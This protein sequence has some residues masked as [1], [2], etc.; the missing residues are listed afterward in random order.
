MSIFYKDIVSNDFI[1]SN[2]AFKWLEFNKKINVLKEKYPNLMTEFKS[3]DGFAFPSRDYVTRHKNLLNKEKLIQISNVN[4]HEWV[5]T[6]SQ[7]F[8]YL[9]K[10]FL[11]NKKR[12]YLN[13]EYILI[14][15][16]GGSDISKDI[17]SYFDNSFNAF[18]NQ[19]V[20]AFYTESIDKDILFYFYGFTKS[21]FFKEQWL[22]KGGIQKNTGA[23]ERKN[24]YIP[25]INKPK[26]ITYISLLT[27]AIINKEKII[28]ER[29]KQILETIENELV[30]NQKSEK[31]DFKY[32]T[33]NEISNIG[34]MDTN[35]YRENFKIIDFSIKNYKNGFQTIFDLGFTLS[36]GQNLQVSNIGK[37]IYSKKYHKGFYSLMLPKH[38]SKYGTIDTKAYLGNGKEL[39]TLKK[40]DLIFGAEGFEKGRSIVIIEEKE[41]AITN[42]HGITIQQE[43]HNLTK[44][45]FVKCFLDY[46]RDNEIIDLFAVGGNGGSL[47]QKYWYYIPFPKFSEITQVNLAK[48]YYNPK[49]ENKTETATLENFLELDNE[50]NEQA[51]IYEL[52]KTAKRLKERLDE[53]IDKIA[54]DEKIEIT[55]KTE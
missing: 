54:N 47:A 38:L 25:K 40:G 13:K 19:R 37:S 36:R 42:I 16:T 55:F 49:T 34:R 20:S 28:R 21:L 7:K 14:S 32:P 8:E 9:P 30:N 26:I 11:E 46:L 52:D 3:F 4:D 10:I 44:A 15:L 23:K 33:F 39:K 51:G 43:E 2:D 29:H 53:V 5:I 22:G 31:F 48:L 35:L 27:Q 1:L 24:L 6:K 45:I 18:L 17:S 12:Y 50:F 41:K